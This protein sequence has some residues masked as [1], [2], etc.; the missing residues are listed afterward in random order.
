MAP[1]S[2]ANWI[3]EVMQAAVEILSC[4]QALVK[5]LTVKQLV[6]NYD[7]AV[8]SSLNDENSSTGKGSVNAS[9]YLQ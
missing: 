3:S 8:Q 2:P 7:H 9:V 1:G 5:L 4:K 6:T